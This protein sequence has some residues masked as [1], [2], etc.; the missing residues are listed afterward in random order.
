MP[1]HYDVAA[2]VVSSHDWNA[3]HRDGYIL[4]EVGPSTDVAD[5]IAT[6]F[7]PERRSLWTVEAVGESSNGWDL[8]R[9]ER[10]ALSDAA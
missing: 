5:V 10:T 8:Y 1:A 6:M 4:L 7:P 9:L 3:K 2:Y